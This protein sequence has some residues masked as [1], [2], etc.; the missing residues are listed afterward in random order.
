MSKMVTSQLNPLKECAPAIVSNFAAVTRTYQLVYCYSIIKRNSRHVLPT[1][2]NNDGSSADV[3]TQ[4]IETY[5]PF[6]PYV[7][8]RYVSS[9]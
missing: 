5:F 1:V 9:R 6:D 3:G 2:N 7:L 8:K 4:A